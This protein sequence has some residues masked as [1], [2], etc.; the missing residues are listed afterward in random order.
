MLAAQGYVLKKVKWPPF[1]A[2]FFGRAKKPTQYVLDL[3]L[4]PSIDEKTPIPVHARRLVRY[5]KKENFE[6]GSDQ[7]LQKG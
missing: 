6:A 5:H 1:K 7:S 2:K 3:R 4:F